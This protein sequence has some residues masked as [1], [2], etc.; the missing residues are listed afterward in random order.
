MLVTRISQMTG[1]THSREI[2]IT[3]A[4]LDEWDS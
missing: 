3:Q 1:R 4:T 2:D